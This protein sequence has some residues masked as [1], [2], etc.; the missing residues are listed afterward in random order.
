MELELGPK[1][2]TTVLTIRNS[3]TKTQIFDLSWARVTQDN[4]GEAIES[5][6]NDLVVF[7]RTLTLGPGQAG[8]VR[9]G[10]RQPLVATEGSF[11]IYAQERPVATSAL[12]DSAGETD[13]SGASLKIVFRMSSLLLVRPV[14]EIFSL[15]WLDGQVADGRAEFQLRNSGTRHQIYEKAVVTA[16]DASGQTVF[17]TPLKTNRYLLAGSTRRFSVPLAS[18]ACERIAKMVLVVTTNKG[19]ARQG[20]DVGAKAC[21]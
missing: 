8:V 18:E 5:P 15:Q 11:L 2:R 17:A 13:V 16:L 9:V 6:S 10:M 14:K 20:I 12:T 7:P 3:D 19:E 1:A 4:A 21:P